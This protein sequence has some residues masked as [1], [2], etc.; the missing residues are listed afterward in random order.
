MAATNIS[1]HTRSTS[2]QAVKYVGGSF[3]GQFDME[4]VNRLVHAHF[5]IKVKGSDRL[6]FVDHHGRECWLYVA[7]DP[8]DTELGKTFLAQIRR[9]KAEQARQEEEREAELQAVLDSMTTEQ[10][11]RLL[12]GE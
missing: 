12:K 7:V 1:Y 10:A 2:D 11:L 8:Q 9:N 5:N 3:G 4:T 6:V